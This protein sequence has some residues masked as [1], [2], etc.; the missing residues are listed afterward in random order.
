MKNGRRPTISDVANHAGIS[1][2]T[3]SQYLNER[4][5]YMGE[6]TKK[7]IRESIKELEYSPNFLAK[8]LKQKK[9]YTIGIIVANIL[10]GFSTRVIRTIEDVCNEQNIHVIVCNTDEDVNKEQKYVEMLQAKQVDG[11]IIFPAGDNNELYRELLNQEIPLVFVDRIIPELQVSTVLTDNEQAAEM[12]VSHFV[13]YGHK[14]IGFVLPPMKSTMTPR[15]ERLSGF[16]KSMH[17]H[18]LS[19][20]E[21][22]IYS[23][24][25]TDMVGYLK[26]RF[27]TAR[28][29]TALVTSNDL[30]LV[31]VLRFCKEQAIVIP[32]ELSI[33]SIDDMPLASVYNPAITAIDQPAFTIGAKAASLLLDEINER[34]KTP[35]IYRFS[36]TFLKRE[37]VNRT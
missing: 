22:F 16:R 3:V 9:T 35:G 8:S 24:P 7:R 34:E 20:N 19:V 31:E 21:D 29:P 2:S 33:V 15:T 28:K 36:P 11:F 14:D 25:L 13:E 32:D 4:F 26:S 1:K 23:A 37:T 27:Q 18:S 5:E 10:H 30:T 12:A 6:E 17:R